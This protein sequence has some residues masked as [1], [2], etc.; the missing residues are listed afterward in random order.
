MKLHD[1]K[2]VLTSTRGAIQTCTV[3][4][5]EKCEV[6]NKGCSVEYAVL[7]Y[8]NMTLDRIYTYELELVLSVH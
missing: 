2:N 6:L 5:N 7:T 1:L 8:G 3:W 4:D